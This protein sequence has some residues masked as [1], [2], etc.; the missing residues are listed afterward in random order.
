MRP[1]SQPLKDQVGTLQDRSLRLAAEP[2]AEAGLQA[3]WETWLME[4]QPK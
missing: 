4:G 2:V 1:T 3:E